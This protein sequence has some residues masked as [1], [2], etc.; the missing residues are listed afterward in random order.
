MTQAAPTV[1]GA[2]VWLLA[3]RPATLP[4]AIA[5]VLA[6]S[7]A[8]TLV[9]DFRPGPFVAALL[10]AIFIQ[11]GANYANDFADFQRGADDAGRLG[12]TRATQAG[13]VSARTMAIATAISFA[14]AG[15]CGIYLTIEA[16]WPVLAVG[17]TS[18]VAGYLY[19]GGPWPYGYHGLGDLFVFAFFGVVAVMGSLLRAG[20]AAHLGG[21][22]RRDADGLHRHRDPRRQQPARRRQ[23]PARR[24][25]HAGRHLRPRL[26]ARAVRAAA[27]GRPGADPHLRRGGPDALV[28]DAGLARPAAA[29]LLLRRVLGGPEGRAEGRA[30]NGVLKRTGQLHLLLGVLLALSY[31]W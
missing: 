13:L 4:A 29:L 2:R 30:L 3:A 19:T 27:A 14:L 10:G 1:S 28:V 25:A 20:R 23:R 16:G 18:I 9:V 5:P 26:R 6:G 11:I 31:L 24:Q 17:V 15:A 8:A 22:R 7:A 21:R 12:P